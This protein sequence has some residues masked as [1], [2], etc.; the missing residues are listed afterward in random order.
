MR[1]EVMLVWCLALLLAG[2]AVA[3]NG[4][5]ARC[6]PRADDPDGYLLAICEY[7]V[8]HEIDVSPGRP[9]QYQIL[10]VE[11]GVYR[12]QAVYVIYLDCCYLGDVAYID[13]DTRDVVGFNL[14]AK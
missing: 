1:R 6:E 10:R 4:R 14:G 13:P 5:A 9:D 12:D 3:C 8:Q 11:D 7:I 2:L